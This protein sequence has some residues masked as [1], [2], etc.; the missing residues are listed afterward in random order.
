M[1]WHD[2]F[3]SLINV[4]ASKSKDTSTKVGCIIV[5]K[6][7]VGISSGFNGFPKG[8]NDNIVERYERPAKYLWTEHAERNAI[9]FAA[10]NGVKLEGCKLYINWIPCVNCARA[11]IQ[12]G[13]KEVI[14]NGD[15]EEYNNKELQKRWED[16]QKISITMFEESGIKLSIIKKG[17]PENFSKNFRNGFL[18]NL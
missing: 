13:I 1:T 10:R 9:Y 15:S 2:Y 11:I 4:I 16:E 3:F 6:D 17:L 7:N 5:S 8:V 12:S 14:V 18:E